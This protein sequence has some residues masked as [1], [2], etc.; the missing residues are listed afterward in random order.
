MSEATQVAFQIDNQRLAEIDALVADHEFRSR[1]EAL[2]AAVGEFLAQRREARVD[3][4]LEAGYRAHPQGADE[5]AWAEISVE[6]LR[7]ADLD[8]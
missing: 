1:A 2:R 4:Q 8:W 6:S 7:E 5:A 3:A